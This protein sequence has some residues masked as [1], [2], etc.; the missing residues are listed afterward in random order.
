MPTG[1]TSA[2]TQ[3]IN[4]NGHRNVYATPFVW[5]HADTEAVRNPDSFAAWT[6]NGNVTELNSLVSRVTFRN[7]RDALR[8]QSSDPD[9][10]SYRDFTFTTDNTL[11]SL[12]GDAPG[13]DVT[14]VGPGQSSTH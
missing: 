3:R 2:F 10:R 1:T 5:L 9:M 7:S 11:P 14:Q 8:I 4:W 6:G 13:A 12:S